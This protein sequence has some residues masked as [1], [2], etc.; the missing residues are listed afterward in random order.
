MKNIT[1]ELWRRI[2]PI[3]DRAFQL[4]EGER[5][6]FLEDACGDDG[7]L[8]REIEE[9]LAAD[10]A[11]SGLLSQPIG[12]EAPTLVRAVHEQLGGRQQAAPTSE[13]ERFLPGARLGGRFRIVEFL[14]R[15]G[16]GEV[17]RADDLKLGQ[18]V[19]LKFLPPEVEHDDAALAR[20]ANEVRMALKVSHPNVT[21]VHDIAELGGRHFI[22]MEFVDGEDLSSLLRRIGRLPRDKAVEVARQ[23]CSGL[24]AAHDQGVLHRDLKPANVMLDGRGRVK[25]TDFGLA[26]L[27]RG[28]RGDDVRAGT[29]QYMAPEQWASQ[30]VSQRSD[31]YS[32]G[33]ILYELF[34]GRAAFAGM[35]PIEIAEQH[36]S[37]SSP[38]A[39]PSTL[40]ESFD[41][42]VERLVLRCLDPDPEKRPRSA[43]AVAAALPGGDPL[44]AALLAG[45]TPSPEM[46]AD[47][48]E[49]GGLEPRYAWSLLIVVLALLA[50]AAWKSERFQLS[51]ASALVHPP[52]VLAN[53]AREILDSLGYSEVQ[54]ERQ[55]FFLPN[56]AYLDHLED[57]RD[58]SDRWHVL[59]ESQP[60]AY[61][62]WYRQSLTQMTRLDLARIDH[63]RADPPLQPGMVELTLDS[64][65]RLL[66]FT[67]ISE[68]IGAGRTQKTVD[69]QSLLDAAGLEI[70][71][72]EEIDPTWSP[73]VF[74]SEQRAWQPRQLEQTVEAAALDGRVVAFRLFGPWSQPRATT[75]S[76]V[77]TRRFGSVFPMASLLAVLIGAWFAWRNV[78]RG[79][80]DLKT[81]W[82]LA[83][84]VFAARLT[85]LLAAD[86][87]ADQR[88]IDLVVAHLAQATYSAGSIWLLYLGAEPY[89]RR[90]WP[91]MFTSWVR[92]FEGR[93]RDP[94][95]GR[96]LLIGA[97]AGLVALNAQVVVGFELREIAGIAPAM[98]ASNWWSH[99]ALSGA[100]QTVAAIA[101]TASSQ[102][103]FMF[104]IV[105]LLT[106]TRVLTRR[107]WV[108]LV[109]MSA[110]A[111]AGASGSNPAIPFLIV[112]PMTLALNWL[113][114]LRFGV[115]SYLT[116]HV[117][118]SIARFLP[119]SV[120]SSNWYLSSSAL[121]LGA[122]L[123]LVFWGFYRALDGRLLR[124]E[125]LVDSA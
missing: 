45:E 13:G 73:P 59:S 95:V 33:L 84:A 38:L 117:V 2:E 97:G 67:A 98:P 113:V 19:A 53:E 54:G 101:A 24:A 105:V 107:T 50:T 3:L 25:I 35:T 56:H 119:L 18:S 90:L 12:Q 123:A 22:S 60:A 11:A 40:V 82:R 69:W 44:A 55:T 15:G 62:Y 81:A 116:L 66:A 16:M 43:R 100:R 8:R 78:R 93:I 122:L 28:D 7:S 108:A 120:D 34:T 70:D 104:G 109:V 63:E 71:E 65:G 115:L 23:L 99:L 32:L 103:L 83:L 110:V 114:L 72:L 80:G 118:R 26:V 121:T 61:R 58:E 51:S 125:L 124:G 9:L 31:L 1:P 10:V 88:E 27:D 57:T 94:L 14:G 17:Y 42:V 87:F 102:L 30:E 5:A 112:F 41:P 29:P 21:R 86:H 111:I 37:D 46:V 89:A 106:I 96:D 76:G 77:G 64:E 39:R 36:R 52:A 74:A 85:W 92:L 49:Q 75:G 91:R 79:R 47:L 68:N 48:G 6:E 4:P 20:L